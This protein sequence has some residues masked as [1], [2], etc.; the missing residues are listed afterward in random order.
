MDQIQTIARFKKWKSIKRLTIVL[1]IIYL[2]LSLSLT[3]SAQSGLST[4]FRDFTGSII[5]GYS[6]HFIGANGTFKI[7]SVHTISAIISGSVSMPG[8]QTDVF[9]RVDDYD[10]LYPE[11]RHASHVLFYGV[12]SVYGTWTENAPVKPVYVYSQDFA[13]HPI[14]KR[15]LAV[16]DIWEGVLLTYGV[17]YLENT[18]VEETSIGYNFTGDILLFYT[19]L[20]K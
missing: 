2:T 4:E 3:L 11:I 16:T 17:F 20:N 13:G 18:N 8:L 5:D 9:P 7:D 1:L 15:N 14:C 12:L 6:R 19:S 10:N